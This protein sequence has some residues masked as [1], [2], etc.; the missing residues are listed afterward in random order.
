MQ[1]ASASTI[2]HRMPAFLE[3]LTRAA[4]AL[5]DDQLTHELACAERCARLATRSRRDLWMA[6]IRC[7]RCELERRSAERSGTNPW[8]GR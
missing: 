6:R 4:Q 8:L 2:T 3:A 7:I 1:D 5:S